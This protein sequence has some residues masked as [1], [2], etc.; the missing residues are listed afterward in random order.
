MVAGWGQGVEAGYDNKFLAGLGV[1]RVTVT[2]TTT[3]LVSRVLAM[4]GVRSNE[5]GRKVSR[6]TGKN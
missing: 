2:H 4:E 6:S 1:G 3:G 5:Q